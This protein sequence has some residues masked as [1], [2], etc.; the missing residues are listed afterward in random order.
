MLENFADGFLGFFMFFAHWLSPAGDQ[1]EIRVSSVR[2]ESSRSVVECVIPFDWNE[3]MSDLIDAGIPMRFRILSYSDA[4]D[5][6]MS[7]RTLCCDVSEYT[8]LFTDSLSTPRSDSVRVSKEYRQIFRI[9]R[10]YQRVT[11]YFSGTASW[12]H[13]EAVL[14]PSRVSQMNRSIDLT[15]ICG[16]R[17]FSRRIFAK[18]LKR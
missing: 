2:E 3:R 16:C 6:V 7:I 13:I 1:G 8:Y 14:L 4:G 11:R 10:D 17:K 12:Y 5:T 15:D 9:V 18:E